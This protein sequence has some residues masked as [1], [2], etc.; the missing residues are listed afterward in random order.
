MPMRDKKEEP[1]ECESCGCMHLEEE[2]C[3]GL[4][5]YRSGDVF[6]ESPVESSYLQKALEKFRKKRKDK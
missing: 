1:S 2:A 6:E 3:E 5:P 4:M